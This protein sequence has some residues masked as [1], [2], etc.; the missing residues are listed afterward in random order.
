MQFGLNEQLRAALPP[1]LHLTTPTIYL[2]ARGLVSFYSFNQWNLFHFSLKGF[3]E[4]KTF[5]STTLK[6][7]F[8]SAGFIFKQQPV[9]QSV[10]RT[11]TS[12]ENG[13]TFIC[14]WTES[15]PD[16]PIWSLLCRK[17]T[18]LM[19]AILVRSSPSLVPLLA[20]FMSC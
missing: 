17:G 11:R 7:C 20:A 13:Q 9:I 4:R 8:S 1:P 14:R 5:D 12:T 16:L 15:P 10:S 19:T 2:K 6:R 18:F 3:V